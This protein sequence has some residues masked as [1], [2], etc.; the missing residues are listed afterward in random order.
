MGPISQAQ[1]GKSLIMPIGPA[2]LQIHRTIGHQIWGPLGKEDL[3]FFA[4]LHNLRLHHW[5]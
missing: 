3:W 1:L 2:G 4:L 5:T